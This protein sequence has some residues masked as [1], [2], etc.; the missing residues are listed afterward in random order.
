ME[1]GFTI[2]A[3]KINLGTT[4]TKVVQRVIA[5]WYQEFVGQ[6]YW[7]KWL[8]VHT[9]RPDKIV[10]VGTVFLVR[11]SCENTSTTPWSSAFLDPGI[12]KESIDLG[13]HDATFMN[14]VVG[15]FAADRLGSTGVVAKLK[16]ENRTT[17]A[18]SIKTVPVI[19]DDGDQFGTEIG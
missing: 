6:G 16:A 11:L 8:V 15:C 5:S 14:A 1:T 13:H 12:V 19:L 17:D 10:N 2:N 18:F 3:D 4:I 7:V 9:K